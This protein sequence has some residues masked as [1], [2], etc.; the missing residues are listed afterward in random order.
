MVKF[1]DDLPAQGLHYPKTPKDRSLNTLGDEFLLRTQVIEMAAGA[2][3]GVE[4]K[5]REN[6]GSNERS[7]A[8]PAHHRGGGCRNRYSRPSTGLVA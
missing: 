5:R 4:E 2:A 3:P 6:E 8:I 7:M 1:S